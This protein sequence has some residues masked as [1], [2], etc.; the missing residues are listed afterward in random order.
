MQPTL[1]DKQIEIL[2]FIEREV[3]RIGYPPAV[4]EICEAVGLQSTSTVHGHLM[5]L[6]KKGYIRRDQTK[7]RAI[8]V[9][10]PSGL[11]PNKK[12]MTGDAA[13][14]IDFP[15]Q[16]VA[17]IPIIGKVT[18]GEPILALE[19][20]EHTFPVPIDFVSNGKY[21]MLK[22][23]GDS[24]IEVGILNND[25]VLVRQQNTA[26]NGDKVVAMIDD[27]AT[28]KTYYKEA[29]R[30]RLQP[31]NSALEPIYT[32]HVTILG[33]VRGVFRKL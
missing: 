21:F 17:N 28:V 7:P 11:V 4:R 6:E 30:F 3:A 1:T 18:A 27:S 23:S 8:E 22:V 25:H 26:N 32:D 15:K 12:A 19:E 2:A 5:R 9:V 16:E 24:M 13:V 33:V 10:I 29:N 14:V 31:E 20:Y